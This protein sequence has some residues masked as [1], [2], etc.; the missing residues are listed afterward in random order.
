MPLRHRLMTMHAPTRP[1]VDDAFFEELAR[2]LKARG[3]TT[4]W[5]DPSGLPDLVIMVEIPDALLSGPAS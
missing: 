1:F 2:N 3:V 5:V 4:W